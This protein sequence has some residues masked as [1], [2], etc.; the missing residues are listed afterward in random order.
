MAASTDKE[1]VKLIEIWSED[2][3][4]D[5]LERCRKN[6]QVFEKIVDRLKE[7]GFDRT[8]K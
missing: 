7:A 1:T 4:Q 3:I 2:R 6:R 5:E 8:V